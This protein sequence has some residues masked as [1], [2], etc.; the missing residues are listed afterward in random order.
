MEYPRFDPV[1]CEAVYNLFIQHLLFFELTKKW[2]LEKYIDYK[3][4][5]K[6]E[7]KYEML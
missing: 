2:Q 4:L 3:W 6:L 1:W 7:D 5:V